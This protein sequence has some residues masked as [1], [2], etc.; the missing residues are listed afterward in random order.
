MAGVNIGKRLATATVM[1]TV[2][3]TISQYIAGWSVI[4]CRIYVNIVNSIIVFPLCA[5]LEY[6][7]L[8]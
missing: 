6:S 2:L 1:I 5:M 7:A 3:V 4:N 8:M